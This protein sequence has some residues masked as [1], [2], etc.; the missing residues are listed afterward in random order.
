MGVA[1]KYVASRLKKA[2][3]EYR[4][5]SSPQPAVIMKNSLLLQV[6]EKQNFATSSKYIW[7]WCTTYTLKLLVSQCSN[8]LQAFRG[9]P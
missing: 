4:R 5:I 6:S 8:K 9:I 3:A 2:E 1:N 7:P